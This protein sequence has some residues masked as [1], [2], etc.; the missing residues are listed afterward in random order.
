MRRYVAIWFR[1][2]LTDRHIRKHP[3]M[4]SIPFVM[5]LPQRGRMVVT[6]SSATATALGIVPGM[7]V[8][9]ARA[10]FPDVQVIEEKETS[11][12]KLL[13]ALAE[14]AIRFTPVVAI[15]Q[16][17][18]LLLDA[19][20]CTHLWQGETAYLKDIRDR[21]R[22]FGYHIRVA[23]AGTPGA[24][25][26]LARF[27]EEQV[28]IP[29]GEDRKAI[30]PLPPAALR[31]SPEIVEK[32]L[33]LG[34]STVSKFVDMPRSSLRRRFGPELSDRIDQVLGKSTEWI[35]PVEPAVRYR[36]QL[37]CLEPICTATAIRIAIERLL[38]LLCNRLAKEHKGL[39]KAILKTYRLD[40]KTQ[41][42]EIGTYRP[43]CHIQHLLRLFALKINTIEPDLG[44]EL[45][46]LEAPVVT[47]IREE[48]GS[49]WSITG[50]K[51]LTAIA[52]LLD[53]MAGR[54]G[55]DIVRRYLPAEHYWPE[56]SVTQARS[57]EEKSTTDWRTDRPRPTH[58]LPCPETI[59]VTAPVP[60][61]P[62]VLF[63]YK[64]EVHRIAKADGPER[65]EQE[66]WLSGG[67][68][69]D[70]YTVEND[71]GA[72]YWIFRS[73]YYDQGTAKWYIHG[74]FS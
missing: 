30:L 24:A 50:D 6:A 36:E 4:K 18:G 17:D 26:A 21:L 27:G 14:W 13:S 37:S 1:H 60:D 69:R 71:Q 9:D 64:D 12:E 32:L 41:Q 48:Q 31:I 39:Q 43:T 53:R 5:A 70:Y 59:F 66:W 63:R 40:G 73:G 38:E 47:G 74:F 28:I 25:W 8:A 49:F 23:M 56:R 45:L 33:K 20:G 52:A 62:P 15:D 34:L 7:V 44:I 54:G 46:I 10:A 16:P 61:Y 11:P 55:H 3:D 22:E 2:L 42:I 35:E 72:R 58:L 65:I 57:L 29:P 19:T 68:H 67:L 51:N